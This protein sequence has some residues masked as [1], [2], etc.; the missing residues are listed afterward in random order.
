[1]AT[2]GTLIVFDVLRFGHGISLIVM[3]IAIAIGIYLEWRRDRQGQTEGMKVSVIVPIHNESYRMEG[4]LRTLLVQTY[5]A[6][7]IFVDDR[8]SDDSPVMLEKFRQD[9]H[10]RGMNCKIITLAENPGVNHKQYALARGIA[11]AAGDYY[12][13]TDGDCEVPPDWIQAMTSRITDEKTGIVI[14]PVFRK[15]EGKGFLHLFQCYDHALRY[16]YLAGACGLGAAGGGFGNNIIISKKALEAAGGY[17]A[18]PLSPTE[19]AALIS[20]IRSGKQFNIH[21]I[22]ANGAVV[23]TAGEKSWRKLINQTLR[24]NNGGLFSPE[25]LTRFN[26]NLLM[27]I[28]GTGILALPLLPFFPK[29]WPLPAGVFISMLINHIAAFV[30]FRRALPQGHRFGFFLTLLFMPCYSTLMTLMGY[31]GIKPKWK[32]ANLP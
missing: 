32:T 1:M 15:K 26:Y 17:E 19:D 14:G 16:D 4:L 10:K 9:A 25:A 22:V 5:Q 28:I 30:F 13:F 3:H 31:A 11:E 21:S 8:S 23:E 20:K 2:G 24:W 6:E 18:I 12:L 27:L 29:L 7:I